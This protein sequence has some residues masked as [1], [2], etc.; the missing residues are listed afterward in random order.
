MLDDPKDFQFLK[1]LGPQLEFLE[2]AQPMPWPTTLQSYLAVIAEH[3]PR[4]ET[5]VIGTSAIGYVEFI[6]PTWPLPK[7]RR[8]GFARFERI[9]YHR[10]H[11]ILFF[12]HLET[13]C[14]SRPELSEIRFLS[15]ASA[16]TKYMGW[17]RE[18][19]QRLH[20]VSGVDVSLGY[21]TSVRSFVS[22]VS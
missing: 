19:A 6:T 3:C 5:I 1:A 8:L 16:F 12:K 22:T 17:I 13:I 18:C 14:R 2:I 15:D 9:D 11:W 20:N 21:G 10:D 4:L 7:I